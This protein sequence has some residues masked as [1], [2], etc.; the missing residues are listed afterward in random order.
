MIKM[1]PL[2]MT[3]N[4]RLVG[5]CRASQKVITKPQSRLGVVSE[6]GRFR[7]AQRR[8]GFTE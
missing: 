8:V 1:S 7:K 4:V 6:S 3:S 5:G 2:E